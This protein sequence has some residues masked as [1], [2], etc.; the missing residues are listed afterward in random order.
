MSVAL[1]QL[2]IH[3]EDKTEKRHDVD[4]DVS[5]EQA[6]RHLCQIWWEKVL[7]EER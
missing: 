2:N 5:S 1:N 3:R 4:I 7:F 6:L